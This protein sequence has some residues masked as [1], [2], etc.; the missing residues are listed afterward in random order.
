MT[1]MIKV[2]AFY[3]FFPI[4]EIRLGKTQTFLK[5]EG[6]RLNVRGLILIGTEGINA[7]VAGS[8]DLLEQYKETIS[9]LFP[10]ECFFYKDSYAQTWN[11]KRLSV[12]IK[13]EIVSVGKPELLL[14]KER[15]RESD[16]VLSPE[17][18]DWEIKNQAQ[19]LDVRNTYETGIGKFQ[20]A[21]ELGLNRFN[22]FPEKIE[23]APLDKNKKTLIYCTGGIRCEKALK[24]MRDQGFKEVYQLK[25]GI[26][27]YLREKPSS[28][29][30]GECFVF[31]HRAAV[32]QNL[33]PSKRFSLCPHCGQPGNVKT[34]CAH[35][36]K[37]FV[38]CQSC[39]DKT[40]FNK[41]CS[42]N[43]AYHFR[44]N[45]KCRKKYSSKTKQK[46]ASGM[47]NKKSNF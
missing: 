42:K 24:I 18:W 39:L 34:D 3:K 30:E 25:G 5:R 32:D 14:K 13:P 29:F 27:N 40:P 43:C 15:N 37:P 45:H 20:R 31:D 36:E 44:A 8:P 41:T 22:E 19:V 47:T 23:K 26:L 10:T 28:F 33:N 4:Q 11:F 1:F 17:E 12:K 46:L 2:T 7:T 16:A 9:Q 35:C 6:S 21:K 38:A